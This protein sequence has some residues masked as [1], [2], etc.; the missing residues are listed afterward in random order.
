M[1]FMKKL[2]LLTFI[3]VGLITSG[4]VSTSAYHPVPTRVIFVHTSPIYS[5]IYYPVYTTWRM[6]Y[7]RGFESRYIGHGHGHGYWH[8]RK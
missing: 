2:S 7:D 3:A 5:P 6:G 8:R 4:C 1:I